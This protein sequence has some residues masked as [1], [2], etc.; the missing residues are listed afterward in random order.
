MD[1]IQLSVKNK[2]EE[3]QKKNS[4]FFDTWVS[5]VVIHVVKTS[6]LFM[7]TNIQFKK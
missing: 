1:W 3:K 5:K 6:T 2:V 7:D 4:L